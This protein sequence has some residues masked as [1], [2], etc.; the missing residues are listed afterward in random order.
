[1]FEGSTKW[2]SL[3]KD[4]DRYGI[5]EVCIGEVLRQLKDLISLYKVSGIQGAILVG[6][7]KFHRRL[8][9]DHGALDRYVKTTQ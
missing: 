8:D 4:F 3:R 1:M 9:G 5:I 2:Q 6:I 7:L